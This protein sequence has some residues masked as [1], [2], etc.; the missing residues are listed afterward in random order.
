M[1]FLFIGML[2]CV[3]AMV[4]AMCTLAMQRSGVCS[5]CL[6]QLDASFLVTKIH[7]FVENMVELWKNVGV[8]KKLCRLRIP[9][10]GC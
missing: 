10:R 2:I 3:C 4:L 6:H 8:H 9:L 7:P 1:T 5:L